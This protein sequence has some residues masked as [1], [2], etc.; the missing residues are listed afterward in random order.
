MTSKPERIQE[1]LLRLGNLAGQLNTQAQGTQAIASDL[2]KW[3]KSWLT[4]LS[5]NAVDLIDRIIKRA[6]EQG[7]DMSSI[8][9]TLEKLRREI[10]P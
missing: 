10:A 7:V 4:Q 3:S 9:P 6:D 2:Q 1:L 5:P 8:Q